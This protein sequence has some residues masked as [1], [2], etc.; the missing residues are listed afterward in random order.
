[1]RPGRL[2]LNMSLLPSDV[3]RKI[4]AQYGGRLYEKGLWMSSNRR[5]M[6]DTRWIGSLDVI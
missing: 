5:G 3:P 6:D 4:N 1:M 2:D